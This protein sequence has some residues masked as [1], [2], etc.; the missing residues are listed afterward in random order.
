M[1]VDTERNQVQ[2]LAAECEG[3]KKE[4]AATK[5]K[6]NEEHRL[7]MQLETLATQLQEDTCNC[8]EWFQ[9]TCEID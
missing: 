3:L 9:L 4:S 7:R 8:I 5:Q 2:L 6:Y 1:L